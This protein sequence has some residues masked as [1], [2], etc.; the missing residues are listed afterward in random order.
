M[1]PLLVGDVQ[2]VAPQRRF[3]HIVLHTHVH[4]YSANSVN[5]LIVR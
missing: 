3:P 1:Q 2:L 5:F 4:N